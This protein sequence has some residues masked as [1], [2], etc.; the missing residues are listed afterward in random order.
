M[1]PET[2]SIRESDQRGFTPKYDDRYWTR[3]KGRL[4]FNFRFYQASI[5]T[6][7]RKK[8][9][10]TAKTFVPKSG[11]FLAL[12]NHTN[13]LDPFFLAMMFPHYV[14]FVAAESILRKPVS[15]PLVSYLQRPIGRKKGN[16]G[17]EASYYIRQNLM[18]GISVAMFPE[19]VRTINGRTGFISPRTGELLK[20]TGAGL[21]TCRISGG[22]LC[23]PLWSRHSRRG[24]VWAEM[25]HEYTPEELE[26]M[27][28]DEINRAIADDLYVNAYD[29]QRE[30]MLP[31]P[32]EALAEGLENVVYLCPR[33]LQFDGLAS[34]GDS[35]RCSCGLEAT[36]DEYGFFRGENLP[37]DNVCDWESWQRARIAEYAE[38]WRREEKRYICRQKDVSFTRLEDTETDLLMGGAE[39]LLYSDRLVFRKEEK[40]LEFLL[41]ELDEVSNFR[42][43]ALIFTQDGRRYEVRT[44]ASWPV[45]K[46][47]TLIRLL[48]GKKYL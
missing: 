17:A 9:G 39:M 24:R 34:S 11:T 41:K 5:G 7:V 27:S 43:S 30:K 22:Y 48:K 40:E 28:L 15:G 36:L 45:F 38:S 23:N 12:V 4:E 16:S 35:Y 31:Y 6:W 19:G 1:A 21:V 18:N 33:C 20:G 26:R 2:D 29:V 8:F 42:S 47:I 46:Y 32:G 3:G 37:F 25:V 10:Y 14:R 13:D 44:G